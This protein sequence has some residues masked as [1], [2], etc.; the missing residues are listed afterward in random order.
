VS[1]KAS[2]EETNEYKQLLFDAAKLI[3]KAS[4]IL[5][6]ENPV[7]KV[8]RHTPWWCW[9]SLGLVLGVTLYLSR[10]FFI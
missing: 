6:E 10:M 4:K 2:I 8:R 5:P 3:D 1:I 7:V 9:L